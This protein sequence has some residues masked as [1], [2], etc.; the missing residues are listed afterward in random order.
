[1]NNAVEQLQ[2][3]IFLPPSS[4]FGP[5]TLLISRDGED[6][7]NSVRISTA[8]TSTTEIEFR[9]MNKKPPIYSK[10]IYSK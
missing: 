1:M 2:P 9:N 6:D 10:I 5:G 8:R 3:E 4:P 7:V